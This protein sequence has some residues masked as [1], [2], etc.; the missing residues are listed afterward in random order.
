ML[1]AKQWRYSQLQRSVHPIS[2]VASLLTSFMLLACLSP[3]LAERLPQLAIDRSEFPETVISASDP[4]TKPL[5]YYQI[6][7]DTY[8]LYGNIAEVDVRNRGFN[9]NA[10][11]V[12]TR[13]GVVVIDSLGTP[14]LGKRLIATVRHVTKL[15]IKFLIITHNHPDHSYGAI[16]FRNLPGIKIIAHEGTLEYHNSDNFAGSVAY[17]RRILA[18]D[19]KEFK[20]VAPDILVGGKPYDKYSFSLGGKTFAIFNTAQHHSY[21]DLVVHQIEDRNLWIS[22]LAFNHRATYM[23]DGHSAEILQSINWLRSNFPDIRLIIPGHGS[24]QTAPFAM[25]EKTYDYVK[26]LRVEMRISVIS[27]QDLATAVRLSDFADWHDTPL[28]N[29]NHKKNAN[30]VYLEMEQEL[31]LGK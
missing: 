29:E 19:M 1:H 30:F 28:Y 11:F 17:R 18:D 3:A 13:A 6:A 12:V 20:G 23:G 31:F 22:D 9:G 4:D 2:A 21:G 25:V 8:F 14:K 7:A 16:A 5:P 27:G 15:P 10:G 26:R 24:A